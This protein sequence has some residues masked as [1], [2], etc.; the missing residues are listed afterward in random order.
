MLLFHKLLAKLG[1]QTKTY[2][3]EK[4]KSEHPQYIVMSTFVNDAIGQDS[5]CGYEWKEYKISKFEGNDV[6]FLKGKNQAYIAAGR[7]EALVQM[8][9]YIISHILSHNGRHS[10]T[11]NTSYQY[12]IVF[13]ASS[14]GKYRIR[15]S[16]DKH[17]LEI[18]YERGDEYKIYTF[19]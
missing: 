13:D 19:S 15:F 9:E 1:L 18:V 17:E 3:I 5:D 16:G 11:L 7:V 6:L 10:A 14:G 8:D 2:K 12:H 4:F